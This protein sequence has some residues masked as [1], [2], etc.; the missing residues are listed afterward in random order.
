MGLK[1][2]NI[3]HTT[4]HFSGWRSVLLRYFSWLVHLIFC[5]YLLQ[6]L[7]QNSLV[8]IV[9]EKFNFL[10]FCLVPA[11]LEVMEHSSTSQYLLI[12]KIYHLLELIANVVSTYFGLACDVVLYCSY[13]WVL[14]LDT[15]LNYLFCISL[16]HYDINFDV[17][18]LD[19]TKSLNF[20]LF[21]WMN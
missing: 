19:M 6:T 5:E 21:F 14:F 9:D 13:L 20:F 10:T 4:T 1:F 11:R 12:K 16:F 15:M 8:A 2:H 3:G 17:S 18:S 7:L